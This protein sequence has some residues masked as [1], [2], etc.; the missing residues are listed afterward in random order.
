MENHLFSLINKSKIINDYKLSFH[1]GL[2]S[3]AIETEISIEKPFPFSS[4]APT[5]AWPGARSAER[6]DAQAAPQTRDLPFSAH[7][8]GSETSPHRESSPSPFPTH[9]HTTY[10]T[11]TKVV[12][13]FFVASPVLSFVLSLAASARCECSSSLFTFIGRCHRVTQRDDFAQ[14]T[15]H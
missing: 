4:R 2:S 5:K 3:S 9:T 15:L 14:R 10:S 6:G 11:R 1:N 13:R 8:W 12:F 7:T